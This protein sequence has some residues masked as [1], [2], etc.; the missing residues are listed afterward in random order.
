MTTQADEARQIAA[1]NRRRDKDPLYWARGR[2][3]ALRSD[4]ASK[5][6]DAGKARLYRTR[7]DHQ[8]H[9]ATF[10]RWWERAAHDARRGV[11][12]GWVLAG[13]E[14]DREDPS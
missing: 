9:A 5:G 4:G 8:R 3:V 6:F 2:L 12:P 11:R 13:V 14:R 10:P 7:E 1:E